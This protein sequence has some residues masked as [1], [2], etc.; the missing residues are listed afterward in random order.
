MQ[1]KAIKTRIFQ[2]NEDLL[3][4]IFKYVKKLPE[5]SIL[6]VTSKI[7]ALSEGRTTEH[8]G[9]KQKIKLIKQESS[10]ALKTKYTWLTIKDGIVMANAGIDESNAMGKIILLPKN[11]FKS[12][13]IIRKRLQD[14][15]GIKNLGILITDSRLFPLRAGIAGVALGYAGFEGIKNYIGEKD[16]FGRI[17]KMSKTDVADS[18][19]TSAVLC[20]GE[21]KEQQPLAI[22]TDAPVVF[23]DKVKK[24]ELIIDPK[25]DIYAPLF[26]K[27]NAKK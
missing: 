10:F 26:S 27:L 13:E 24:S 5:K 11:S 7:V 12:A 21:G 6:V 16:I 18:L 15:F 3:K 4:F 1:I 25:K 17:L 2:K 20:M 22:I 8:K 14:K 9:E 23:T 19:A